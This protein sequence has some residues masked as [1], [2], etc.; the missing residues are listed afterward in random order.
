MLGFGSIF[1]TNRTR[2]TVL[3]PPSKLWKFTHF[4]A[5]E[6]GYGQGQGIGCAVEVRD[7]PELFR[8]V[9]RTDKGFETTGLEPWTYL[10]SPG[11]VDFG[12]FGRF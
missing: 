6:G 11:S 5:S 8:V 9:V 4:T 12:V 10:L 7:R 1:P 2:C 3:H